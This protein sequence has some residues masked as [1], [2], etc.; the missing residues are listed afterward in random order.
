MSRPS[1][2]EIKRSLKLLSTERMAEILLHMSWQGVSKADQQLVID[3]I[4]SRKEGYNESI[5]MS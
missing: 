3:E 1:T 4:A 2:E 5:E